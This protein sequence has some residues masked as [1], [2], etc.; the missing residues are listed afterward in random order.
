M[1]SA[2]AVAAI[3]RVSVLMVGAC[4]RKQIRQLAC[5]LYICTIHLSRESAKGLCLISNLASHIRSRVCTIR[6]GDLPWQSDMLKFGTS[7]SLAP[8][9]N[10]V[11]RLG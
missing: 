7:K 11:T 2:L 9:S 3:R 8:S 1:V 6:F 4:A 10:W 5:A